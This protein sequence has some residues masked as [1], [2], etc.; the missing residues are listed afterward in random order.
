MIKINDKK[1][2]LKLILAVILLIIPI[3]SVG[4]YLNRAYSYI[5]D[6]IGAAELSPVEGMSTYLINN[7][8]G[9]S[10]STLLY[11]ALGDSL[12]A[13]V[14]TEDYQEILPYLLAEKMTGDDKQVLLNN[15][16][17]P[18]ATAADVLST[19]LP[20]A[21]KDNPDVITLLIGVNDIHNLVHDSEFYG[22]YEEIVRLL[23][24]ETK[25]DIYLINIPLIGSDELMKGPYQALFDARTREFNLIIKEL[26]VK[27]SV[28]YIDLYTP[29]VGLFKRPGVHYSKDSFHP[30]ASGYRL[31]ADIIYDSI[32]Q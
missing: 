31:W 17:F 6:T 7:K 10:T 24:T 30:S 29:S 9:M 27:Y 15:Y 3:I 25:A 2:R 4:F 1:R 11:A 18:G 22:N 8:N 16:S 5:Y 19:L 14:G 12:T 20:D 28:K 21:I 26:A 32:N 23:K 13:G